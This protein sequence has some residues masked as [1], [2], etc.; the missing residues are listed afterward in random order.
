MT[1]YFVV[2]TGYCV[3]SPN[4]NKIEIGAWM[5]RT[6]NDSSALVSDSG[7]DCIHSYRELS[8]LVTLSNPS[9]Q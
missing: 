3:F 1:T 7:K 5:A 4:D 2:N 9:V 8:H 6:F